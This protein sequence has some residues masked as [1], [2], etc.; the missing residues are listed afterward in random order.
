MSE[1][2][3]TAVAAMISLLLICGCGKPPQL[4]NSAEGLKACDALWTAIGARSPIL[5]RACSEK[6]AALSAAGDLTPEVA[7]HLQGLIQK[8]EE[9]DW[10]SARAGLKKF[11]KGQRRAK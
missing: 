10:D 9:G 8:A 2:R 11:I 1:R 6:I 3:T 5:L 7:E 4:G